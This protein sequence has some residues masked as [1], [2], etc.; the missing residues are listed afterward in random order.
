MR[1]PDKKWWHIDGLDDK[2]MHH[3]VGCSAYI[4]CWFVFLKLSGNI[5]YTSCWA[6]LAIVIAGAAKEIWDLRQ[7]KKRGVKRRFDWADFIATIFCGSGFTLAAI[8][9]EIFIK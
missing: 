2:Q 7:F 4:I 8:I 6:W 1:D 9:H 3:A 5:L